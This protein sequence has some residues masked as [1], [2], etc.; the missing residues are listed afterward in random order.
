MTISVKKGIFTSLAIIAFILW[1][2]SI[3]WGLP[4]STYDVKAKAQTTAKI[5]N[6]KIMPGYTTTT[7]LI[8]VTSW[9]IEKPGGFFSNDVT[10]PGLFMDNMPAFEYAALEQIRDLSL[11]MRLDFSRLPSQSTGDK[12][13]EKAQEKINTSHNN[14]ALPSAEKDY[15]QAIA[16]LVRYRTRL[17]ENSKSDAQFY[18]RA[19]NLNAWLGAVEK[20]LVSLSQRLSSSVEQDNYNS[21]LAAHPS[22]KQSTETTGQMPIQTPWF[23]IDDVFYESRGATWAILHFL[24]SV[25]VDFIDVLEKKNAQ[26]KLKQIIR[27]LEL[28]QAALWSP[29]I[30]NGSGFGLLANHSLVMADYVSRA[31]ASLIELRRLL[32]LD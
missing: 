24:K 8:D 28:T 9:L 29:V 16:S 7:T 12:D 15:Q 5:N 11:A 6:H 13:L 21:P 1:L 14:W 20:R 17:V 25:E 31:K 18:P 26:V 2:I 10:P 4:P 23:Q 3:W 27:E 22:A 30:L 32:A 19:D